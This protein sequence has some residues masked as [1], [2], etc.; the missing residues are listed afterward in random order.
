MFCQH[1]TI[2]VD[3]DT[4]CAP[5]SIP[6]SSYELKA[7]PM[8]LRFSHTSMQWIFW[9]IPFL[10]WPSKFKFEK[11]PLRRPSRMKW[12]TGWSWSKPVRFRPLANSNEPNAPQYCH[13]CDFWLAGPLSYHDHLVGKKHRKNVRVPATVFIQQWWRQR[14]ASI[15]TIIEIEDG[16][17]LVCD[18]SGENWYEGPNIPPRELKVKLNAARGN[19]NYPYP[20]IFHFVYRDQTV[21]M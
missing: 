5:A 7:C 12:R 17:V 20:R 19:P 3:S 4:T 1:V 21:A 14:F 9:R 10:P 8:H 6:G 18:M 2:V 16:H 13:V 15:A 11:A